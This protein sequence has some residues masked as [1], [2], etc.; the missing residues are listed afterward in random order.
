MTTKMCYLSA[1][2]YLG[3]WKYGQQMAIMIGAKQMSKSINCFPIDQ[4]SFEKIL[5]FEHIRAWP[6]F[7]VENWS[8]NWF[9]FPFSLHGRYYKI[10]FFTCTDQ[11]L[12]AWGGWEPRIPV[13]IFSSYMC[14]SVFLS[15]RIVYDWDSGLSQ[16][17]WAFHIIHYIRFGLFKRSFLSLVF[18]MT[19]R[20]SRAVQASF[21]QFQSAC[22]VTK[23]AYDWTW[24]QRQLRN[25]LDN[26]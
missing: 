19:R 1:W 4:D 22:L 15:W 3:G 12:F 17:R 24:W 25:F 23:S 2:I 13:T 14:F 20:D 16:D 10:A 7:F 18:S 9:T 5:G 6:S 21:Y 11:F 26:K 8:V